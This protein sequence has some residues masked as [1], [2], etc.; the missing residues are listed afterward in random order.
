MLKEEEEN[1]KRSRDD[2]FVIEQWKRCAKDQS[3]ENIQD[4]I[5]FHEKSTMEARSKEKF[6]RDALYRWFLNQRCIDSC[7]T[8]EEFSKT[9]VECGELFETLFAKKIK[10]SIKQ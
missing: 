9:V 2:S 10:N 6:T 3:D 1:R 8:V 5:D 4:I 7:I